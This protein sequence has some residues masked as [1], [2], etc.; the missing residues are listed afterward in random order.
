MTDLEMLK[1]VCSA[2]EDKLKELMSSDE[3]EAF[4]TELAKTL[5]AKD[6]ASMPDS[7]FKTI[8]AENFEALTGDEE[9]FNKLMNDASLDK[10]YIDDKDLGD[11]D[12]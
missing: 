10:Y 2:Y 7:E 6:I 1:L 9:E 12:F 5:F 3:Y 4:T 8:C 11:E